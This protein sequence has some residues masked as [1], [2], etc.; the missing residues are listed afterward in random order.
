MTASKTHTIKEFLSTDGKKRVVI[1]QRDD[2]SFTYREERRT[3]SSGHWGPLWTSAPLCGSEQAAER[4]AHDAVRW[5]R[6]A[7]A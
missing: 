1:F 2:G 3:D 4:A 7:K 6:E 5:L